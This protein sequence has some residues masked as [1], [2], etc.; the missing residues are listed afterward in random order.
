MQK[1]I[2]TIKKKKIKKGKMEEEFKTLKQLITAFRDCK[3][4]ADERALILREKAIIRN[5][6]TVKKSLKEK[7][8][9]ITAS[10]PE[11]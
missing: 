11:T 6:F 7:S 3:T 9:K 2:I 4:K 8:K 5:S 10:E 1:K